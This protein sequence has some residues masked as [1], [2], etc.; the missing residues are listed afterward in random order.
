MTQN[1]VV[2]LMRLLI[3][4][5]ANRALLRIQRN[6]KVIEPHMNGDESSDEELN[7]AIEAN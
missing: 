7:L 2:A 5:K 1:L 6:F 3:K 4:P